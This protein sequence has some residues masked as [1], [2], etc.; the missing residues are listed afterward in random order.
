LPKEDWQLRRYAKEIGINYEEFKGDLDENIEIYEPRVLT[1]DEYSKMI[2]WHLFDK[3]NESRLV[4]FRFTLIC[5]IIG[6]LL[7]GIVVYE[8]L[9]WVLKHL[10]S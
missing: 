5:Y 4:S 1:K 7:I 8:N 10:L 3:V 6:F 2:F 9:I